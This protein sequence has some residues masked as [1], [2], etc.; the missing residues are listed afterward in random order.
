M[1]MEFSTY[2]LQRSLEDLLDEEV[3]LESAEAD[4]DIKRFVKENRKKSAVEKHVQTF[5]LKYPTARRCDVEDSISEA[6][7]GLYKD[8]PASSK[9]AVKA[10]K[11][12]VDALLSEI[13]KK[14]KE[15]KRNIS[16]LKSIKSFNSKGLDLNSVIGKAKGLLSSNERTALELCSSGHSV[17]EMGSIMHVSFPT[18]WRILNRALDKVRISHGM[19]SRHRDKR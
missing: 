12:R 15:T 18:A 7:G 10:F 4:F 3:V 2:Y 14:G 16:C 6:L 13:K 8:K 19:K 9:A 1:Y 11:K 17:R 5:S